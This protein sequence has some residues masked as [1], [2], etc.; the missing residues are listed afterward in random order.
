MQLSAPACSNWQWSS[1][2]KAGCGPEAK[3][4]AFG[5]RTDSC[6]ARNGSNN[7]ILMVRWRL[8]SSV[9]CDN[10][11]YSPE[12]KIFNKCLRNDIKFF[13]WDIAQIARGVQTT[14]CMVLYRRCRL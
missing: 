14:R 10:L 3:L 13:V 6:N 2:V 8:I 1:A 12:V 9:S 4:P 11:H 7:V 5:I